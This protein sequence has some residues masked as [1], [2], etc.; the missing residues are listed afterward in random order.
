M[1]SQYFRSWSE[2]I[3]R[4]VRVLAARWMIGVEDMESITELT[5]HNYIVDKE[6]DYTRTVYQKPLLSI[7]ERDQL[8]QLVGWSV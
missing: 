8:L 4:K 2:D 7:G 6:P 5:Q 1:F 3:P